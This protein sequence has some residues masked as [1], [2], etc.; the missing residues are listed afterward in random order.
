ML[1]TASQF[2]LQ[3]LRWYATNRRSLPWR[4]PGGDHGRPDPYRVLVS[5]LMLQQ[6]QVATV[7][8]Y[9]QR[10]L[11]RFPTAAT[12]A[13]A[14]EQEVLRLW[15]GLGYYSRARNLQKAA[16]AIVSRHGGRVPTTV[17]ELLALPGV[18]RYTAGAVASIAHG[19]AAPI[20][21]GNVMRV[22]SRLDRVE[23]NPR[24]RNNQ[25]LLWTRAA[26]LVPSDRPGDFNSAMMELGATVCT[27]R[28]PQCLLCPVRDHCK[29]QAAGVQELIPPPRKAKPT[30]VEKRVVLCV[31]D[32]DNW[33]IE[34]RPTDGRWAGMWQFVSR[35]VESEDLAELIR[36]ASR[37]RKLG[38]VRHQLTHRTYRFDVRWCMLNT[39][40]RP[41]TG[42]EER[43]VPLAGLADFPLPKPHLL[44][45]DLLLKLPPRTR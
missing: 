10:F 43:W 9:F 8:P 15:Q 17:E 7:I 13:E 29:A 44:I 11:E 24:S 18:G 36:H 39:P 42:R 4:I 14:P 5:E 23:G 2:T 1:G 33:L 25:A 26:E 28:N 45:A 12:L 21:D 37:P 16:Q 31:S 35:P 20:L 32:G 19:V 22:L 6:T 34:K 38:Q 3:L 30:P 41:S 40:I 27:P